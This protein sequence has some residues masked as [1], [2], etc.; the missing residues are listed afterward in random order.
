M[1]LTS[2]AKLPGKLI[3]TIA[4]TLA[5]VAALAV[6][7]CSGPEGIEGPQGD[8]GAVGAQGS[9][10]SAGPEGPAG[11]TGSQGSTGAQG[12]K[13]D[14]GSQGP[15][16]AKGATGATGPAGPAG[17]DA[18]AVVTVAAEPESCVVCHSGVG[19]EGHQ[20]IYDDYADE[21]ALELTVDSV[22]SISDGAGAYNATMTLT[23][24]KDGVPYIDVDG[25]PSL[26]QKRFYAVTYDNATSE[27]DN[28]KSF[29]NPVALGNGRYSVTAT[30]ITYNLS[31][32]NG[33]AYAYIAD[34]SLDTESGGHVHLYD[35]VSNA[36][37]AF[38]DVAAYESAATV[39]G[40]EKCHG[41]PYMKHGY[42]AAAV[43]GLPD[44][45]SCKTCHYDTRSGG[46]EDW[47]ILVDDPARFAEVHA[48]DD[49]T[50]EEEAQ[51]AYTANVMNDTHMSHA[52]EFPYPQ[53][54]SNCATCHEGKLDITL[55]DANFTLATCKSCHAVT[56]SEE[57]GTD[58]LALENV[59]SHAWT[60]A[61]VCNSCHATGGIAPVFSAI[62]TGYDSTIYTADGQKYSEAIAVTIDSVSLAGN[63]LNVKFSAAEAPDVPGLDAADIIPTV[64]V[65]LYGYDTKDYIVGPHERDADRNRLLEFMMDGET[66]NPRFTTVP[67]A[68]S[69]WEFIADLSLWA[70]MIA[71]GTVKRAEIAV[72]PLLADIVGEIDSHANG[73]HDDTVYA[74]NAVSRTFDLGG[75]AFDDDFYSPI[76]KVENGCNNC[77]DALATTFHS[78][79][80]GG[81][82]VVCRMCHITKSGGSHLEMQSRSIDSYV[83]A[84]HSFQAFDYDE[85]DFE[86]DVA[87][88]KYEI[89]VEHT[90]PNFTIK[91][92][93]SCHN[94]GMYNV[95]DQSKSLPG[96]LSDSESNDTIDRNIGYV[97]S[98]VTGPASRACG[99]CHRADLINED[100]AGG[101][102]AFNQHAK[103]GGYL[104]EED[105][106]VLETVIE[107]IMGIFE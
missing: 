65:G 93:E 48:G 21:S 57:Y 44:F 97:P 11:A 76:V 70:D 25:L 23:I 89:H 34:G 3:G 71:D 45:A 37:L 49:L 26:D 31:S 20:A 87:A 8:A 47:Q 18:P 17:A 104:V 66:E 64:M 69:K 4:L 55:T 88:T 80:R 96:I 7:G 40:C 13:G 10:G 106:G 42:R 58:E 75:N 41:A 83:H 29:S 16:G 101:L 15:A 19:E 67:T 60:D 63:K 81:S 61:S 27:F 5:L 99:G 77:H 30:G 102:A 98:Y 107:T 92:C 91:N 22:T 43:D 82:V 72:M 52:M 36:A 105:D 74:L 86:D 12:S 6:F 84:A 59:I 68:G 24:M 73:E 35:D 9:A 51:Y 14:T 54:M 103:A 33:L 79:N 62:H 53:S 56:G 32:S 2:H 94:E 78:P 50:A 39:S 46:H 95:P 100:D 90:Y 38:G 1:R 85:V 28:S